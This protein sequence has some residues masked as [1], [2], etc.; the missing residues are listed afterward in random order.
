MSFD[1]DPTTVAFQEDPLPLLRRLRDHHPV[2]YNERLRFWILTRWQDVYRAALDWQIFAN[3]P[4]NYGERD[5]EPTE[6][7]PRWMMDFG[8]F[9]MDPP[10]H[11]R[12]RALLSKTFTPH[13]VAALEPTVRQLAQESLRGLAPKGRFELVH[14]YAAPLTTMVIG[15][16][17]G[18]PEEERWQLRLWGEKIEQRDPSMPVEMAREEQVEAVQAFRSYLLRLVDQRRK[19][20]EDDLLSA[21]SQ[22][23]VDG[24]GL[25]DDELASLSYQLMIAGNETTAML[26][27][28][29]AI[30]LAEQPDQ[31]RLL[32]EEPG[33]VPGAVEEMARYDPAALQS[34]PRITTRPVEMHGQQIPAR[35]PV[36]LSWMGANHDERQFPDPDRFD[37]TRAMERHLGFGFGVHFCVGAALARLE[38]RVAF[39]ELLRVLPDY[40]LDGRPARWA[41]TWLR[42]LGAVPITFDAD[43]ATARVG[44]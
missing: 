38:S 43:E 35:E 25:T 11:N 27:G 19:K 26:I 24:D 7:M 3:D 36:L 42:S 21:L 44:G 8:I 33:L 40:Q 4:V 37:V 14:D 34:P 28:N 10:R 12:I 9:Y 17:I 18:V 13:R 1:F 5:D 20:P 2:Y 31:R 29:G 41:S 22:A 30:H 23:E 16:L 15:A 6:L 32:V 39:E